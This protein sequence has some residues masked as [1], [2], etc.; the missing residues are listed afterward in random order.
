MYVETDILC[1]KNAG[2][3]VSMAR[4]RGV[5]VSRA[6]FGCSILTSTIFHTSRPSF[7]FG[8]D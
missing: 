4:C 1:V 6:P 7:G 8:P 3:D 5:L 2:V